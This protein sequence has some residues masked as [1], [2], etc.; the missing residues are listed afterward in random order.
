ME[1]SNL[2][3]SGGDGGYDAVVVGSG[4]GGS[5]AAC[6]M[7]MA[8]F[9]VC[10]LEKG[11]RWEA[12]DFPTDT[13]KI[14][15]A[16]RMENS[17]LG[18]NIGPK[19]ALFQL[20]IQDD[21][22]AATA[23]GLGGGSLVNA[24]VMISTTARARR[25]PRW[26]KSWEKDWDRCEASAS[27][28]LRVQSIPLK[29]QNS[30]IME[31]VIG[32][33]YD[34]GM[35]IHN[36]IKL[37]MNIE[38]EQ[39]SDSRWSQQTRSCLACGNCLS[40]CPYNAKNSTDKTYLVSAVQAGCTIRT[41]CEVHYVVRNEDDNCKEG[42]M[43]RSSQ[44]RWLVFINEFDYIATDIVVVS[45]GVFGTAKI[46]FQSQLRGLTVSD[47]L[48]S[49]LSCNGNNVAYLAG[50][51]APLNAKG[52]HKT[53]I[54][55]IPFHERPGP[56]ISSSH[57]SS[58]GFTIQSAVVA[59][60]YPSFLFK[61]IMTYGRQS[62]YL[63]LYGLIIDRLKYVLGLK[64]GQEMVLNAMG[65]DDSSGKLMFEKETNRVLFQPP[66]DQ[67][68]PRKIEAFQKLAKK[69]GGVLF[70]SRYRSTSVH[71]LGGC[72]ASPDVSSGVCNPEGQVF[73]AT[74]ATGVH[75]GLYICDASIIPCSVGINPCLTVAAAAEHVS[76][77][78]IQDAIRYVG[79]FKNK[80]SDNRRGSIDDAKMKGSC[81]SDVMTK[82]TMRGQVGGM[83]CTA[84]LK[85]KFNN[86]PVVTVKTDN[87]TGKSHPLL[88]G[89]VG[90]YVECRALE[91]D[92]MHVIQGEVD[93]CKTD[94]RTPYTQ[95]MHYHL[96]LA[97]SSGS[98]YVLE[99]RKIMN[100]YLVALYTWRESTT[101]NVTLRKITDNL[102]QGEHNMNLKGKLHISPLELLKSVSVLQGG[103]RS[104]FVCLLMQ[105][106]VRTYILQL[107]RRS[108]IDFTPKELA[109]EPYPESTVHEIKTEDNFTI[110]CQY[111]KCSYSAR[112]LEHE[113]KPYPVLLINGYATE[114]YCLPSEQNDLVR[115]LLKDGHDIWLLHGREHWSNSSNHFSVED[116]GKLDIP[117]AIRKIIEFYGTNIK[118][119]V[120]AHC[121]GG[122]SIHISLMGGHISAKNIASLSCTNSSMFFKLTTSSSLKM[123]LPLLPISMAIMG[124]DKTLPMHQG[125]AS[126]YRQ[127]LL[128]TVARL[129]PRS[130][131]CTC[132]ECEV[133]SG[134]FGNTFWHE[135]ISQTMHHWMNKQNLPRLPMAAFP[136]L[137]KICNAGFIVDCKGNNC[138]LIHPERMALPTLYVSGGRTIL[139]TPETSFL[140]NKYMKLHQPGYRHERVVV[141]G[142]GHSDILIG[143][144]SSEKVF[145]H[146]QKHIELAE[147]ERSLLTATPRHY[148]YMQEAL[149]WSYDP[150]ED[151]GR[152]GN[153]ISPLIISLL[154]LVLLFKLFF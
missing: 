130:E 67:L 14:L 29:F 68:M 10:L 142:F 18:V 122:V 112:E 38:I 39:V 54:S 58:L 17:N 135:N 59:T 115:T 8:G 134:I 89:K 28:M 65:H 13:F 84:Y 31:G 52:L 41:E 43:K 64:C 103:S 124:E 113:K 150:Y 57:T 45:A 26:P 72:V 74:S 53:E 83:P 111:W 91:I 128:K 104:K 117:G 70:M 139:V 138:Y 71:L 148:S 36:P 85:L 125:L 116:I 46:L 35:D 77:H 97:A 44:R 15:S 109:Q 61:G 27:E 106:L 9:K 47:K 87:A 11:R 95:Y 51:S 73:D 90:G 66:H 107:P 121:V 114:S 48:G 24:G 144:E 96:L 22:L 30:K 105:S 3:D 120:V 137:R 129:M 78:V 153:W 60:A 127:R 12:S 49:G 76:R 102:L 63:L 94:D 108:L 93:L 133:F 69:L 37:S 147:E 75:S 23:C 32:E 154:L 82:E 33:E 40:G 131:R 100:P 145:P 81:G 56:S 1:K 5:V 2:F 151:V 20:H 16:V 101:L 98:R 110:S 99:G 149:E 92:K 42:R 132:D 119:H 86:S 88:R 126:S 79:N 7:S 21:A 118:V 140:A 80:S 136:H 6:R 146:I 4:Y 143:E 34:E 141:D 25:D 62:G 123:W 19:D 55:N 152:Y 50:S